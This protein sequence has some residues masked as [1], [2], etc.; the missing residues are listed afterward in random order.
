M[1][2]AARSNWLQ[3]LVPHSAH[4]YST[5][6]TSENQIHRRAAGDHLGPLIVHGCLETSAAAVQQRSMLDQ[7]RSARHDILTFILLSMITEGR[8]PVGILY[9]FPYHQSAKKT[10]EL[11][12][13]A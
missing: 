10:K 1:H 11:S 2:S 12:S 6:A 4:W 13:L 8:E 3:K 5:T 7:Q 9:L